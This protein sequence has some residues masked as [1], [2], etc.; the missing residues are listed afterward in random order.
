MNDFLDAEVTRDR[1]I[2]SLDSEER[3]ELAISG[4]NCEW[5][6]EWGNG[7]GKAAGGRCAAPQPNLAA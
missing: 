5:V 7:N 1:R 3:Q 2:R 4:V 6:N